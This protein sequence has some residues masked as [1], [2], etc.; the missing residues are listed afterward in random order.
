MPARCGRHVLRPFALVLFE[1]L[2]IKFESRHYALMA[3]KKRGAA[4]GK[5]R[6]G[7]QRKARR[8]AGW[9]VTAQTLDEKPEYRTFYVKAPTEQQAIKKVKEKY[10][11]DQV[12]TIAGKLSSNGFGLLASRFGDD[13]VLNAE[14]VN[15]L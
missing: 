6:G 11:G 15:L 8:G 14:S 3:K 2:E 12:L 13:G 5:A 9:I 1:L 4:R 7:A 10:I